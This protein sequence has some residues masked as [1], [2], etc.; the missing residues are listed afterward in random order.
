M[1]TTLSLLIVLIAFNC[2]AQ[3]AKYMSAMEK[4]V[5]TIDTAKDPATLQNAGN[6]FERISNAN[7]KEWLPLYYQSYCILM[8]GMRETDNGKKDEML[9]KAGLLANRAD[10][11]SKDNSEIY[12]LRSFIN[13]MKISV[14]PMTRGQQ[15]GM[16]SAMLTARAIELDKEN[17]R[18]YLL[19][20]SG[21]MYT[22]PQYG[23][24]KDK[25]IPVLEESVAKYKSFRPKDKIAPHWGE[26][27]ANQL[28][29]QLKTETKNEK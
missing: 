5:A 7:P 18:A 11:L 21:L 16:Q 10:S 13:S 22:P 8:S 17:P 3:D 6:A 12:V 27:R 23:G 2:F 9:D 28:L 14:D 1:K 24:G 19:K 25:A 26:A 20:G 4:N 29:E 15:L